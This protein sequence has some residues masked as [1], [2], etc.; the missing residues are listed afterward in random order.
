[1][2]P[3]GPTVT[4]LVLLAACA[5]PTAPTAPAADRSPPSPAGASREI[6]GAPPN[7]SNCSFADG[8][9]TCVYT[10][11]VTYT[12]T[13][14]A[15]KGCLYGPTGTP[16]SATLTFRDTYEMTVTTTVSQRGLAGVVFDVSTV[17]S[18]PRVLSSTLI[19]YVC[20]APG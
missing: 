2:S 11:L 3:I 5:E 16:S 1:M 10:S 8:T 14:E 18:T 15:T 17:T 7:A 6:A 12:S 9:N 4:V 20:N 13:H 19:A